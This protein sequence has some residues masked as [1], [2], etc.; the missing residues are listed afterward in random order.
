MSDN[1][2]L[3]EKINPHNTNFAYDYYFLDLGNIISLDVS[4]IETL[5]KCVNSNMHYV[6]EFLSF[7]VKSLQESGFNKKYIK[8]LPNSEQMIKDVIKSK[9]LKILKRYI[10]TP[11]IVN[12]ENIKSNNKLMQLLMKNFIKKNQKHLALLT[13]NFLIDAI[14]SNGILTPSLYEELQQTNNQDDFANKYF[15]YYLKAK[16]SYIKEL[17]EEYKQINSNTNSKEQIKGKIEHWLN[18]IGLLL[19][20]NKNILSDDNQDNNK[21]NLSDDYKD[22]EKK[23]KDLIESVKN[24]R[25][26]IQKILDELYDACDKLI[27]NDITVKNNEF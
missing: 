22:I 25:K 24:N 16:I 14:I 13:L 1:E 23:F 18:Y 17:M 15:K 7:V 9:I 26:D 10:K 27:Q 11:T 19:T 20:G 5:N 4:Y 2:S 3:E 8:N 21:L 12:E 6:Y